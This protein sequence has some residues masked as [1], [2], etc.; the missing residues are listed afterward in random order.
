MRAFALLALSQILCAV[1]QA[2]EVLKGRKLHD[3]D[4][5]QSR[6]KYY[7]DTFVNDPRLV[8]K[9]ADFD[10]MFGIGLIVGFILTGLFMVFAIFWIVRDEIERHGT[11]KQK[12]EDDKKKLMRDYD[13]T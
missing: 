2:E 7:T 1:T 10:G 11:Y 13:W 4:K 5:T 6:S 12:I 8:G 3:G 9:P